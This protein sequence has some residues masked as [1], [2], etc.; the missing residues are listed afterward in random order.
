MY[1][2]VK[3]HNKTGLKYLGKTNAKD[4][5]AYH[6]SGTYWTRHLQKHG[7]D[8]STEILL[9]T[10]DNEEIRK[11][12]LYYS[13]LW[14]VVDSEEWANLMNESDD[15]G[16][17]S[18]TDSFVQYIESRDFSG[19]NNGFFGKT[20][21]NETKR[22][23]AEYASK[24]WKNKPKS[25]THKE[26]IAK[27][28]IGKPLSEERKRKISESNKGRTPYNKGVPAEKFFCIHCN[29]IVAGASNYKRWHSDNCKEK[30]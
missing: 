1:L 25:E 4:P 26:N 9:E 22:K 2:Y 5:H 24:Q 12:G 11:H 10:E 23:L 30:K 29:K 8:Y 27:S 14:N 21:S 28:L 16:D 19:D 13:E 17:T 18:H 6:G 15:G 20:H 7:Y 3:T